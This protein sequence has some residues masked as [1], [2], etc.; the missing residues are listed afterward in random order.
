MYN[1]LCFVQAV[2]VVLGV[3]GVKMVGETFDVTLLDPLQS[4][5]VVVGV[6]GA[7]VAASLVSKD[8]E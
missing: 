8:V 6:L 7:G 2:A 5:L 4:L 1:T 3:I